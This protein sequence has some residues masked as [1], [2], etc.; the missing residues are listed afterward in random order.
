[1]GVGG[2]PNHSQ[3]IPLSQW[4]SPSQKKKVDYIQLF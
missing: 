2:I 4:E 1:L 3:N